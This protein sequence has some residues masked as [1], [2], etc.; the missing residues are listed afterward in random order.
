[1]LRMVVSTKWN[2][3]LLEDPL[4]LSRFSDP[5][6]SGHHV[7][8]RFHSQPFSLKQ[9]SCVSM[10]QLWEFIPSTVAVTVPMC[11][12]VSTPQER[13]GVSRWKSQPSDLC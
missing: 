7:E 2:V 11:Q 13:V 1:M 3:H 12:P 9:C 6:S 10:S 4:G 8:V 5:V